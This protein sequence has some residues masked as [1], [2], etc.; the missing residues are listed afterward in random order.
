MNI[1][2]T[3]INVTMTC[4]YACSNRERLKNAPFIQNQTHQDPDSEIVCEQVC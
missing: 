3:H 2:V 1:N 4:G